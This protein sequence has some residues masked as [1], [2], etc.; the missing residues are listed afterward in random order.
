MN[1]VSLFHFP[2]RCF[3]SVK[4]GQALRFVRSQRA[5]VDCRSEFFHDAVARL[6][7]Y[8]FSTAFTM[9]ANHIVDS[10]PNRKNRRPDPIWIGQPLW[11]L[12]PGRASRRESKSS[13]R[14]CR[15]SQT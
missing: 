2:I 12:D 14:S 7:A 6:R 8:K 1:K 11:G 15:V 9:T 3:A 4:R 13:L 5:C 10:E